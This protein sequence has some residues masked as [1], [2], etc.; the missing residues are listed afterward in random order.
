MA[1]KRPRENDLAGA[2][3]GDHDLRKRVDAA[4]DKDPKLANLFQ[5]VVM[6]LQK[7]DS[8]PPNL[9][10]DDDTDDD[11]FD[12]SFEDEAELLAATEAVENGKRPRDQDNE[13]EFSPNKKTKA[14]SSPSTALANR[15]LTERFGLG[16]FRLKQEAVITRILDGGSAVIVFPTGGGKSLCYQV[17]VV[18]YSISSLTSI[19]YPQ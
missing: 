9:S 2:L 17:W 3:A 13:D 7:Q 16:G 15:V 14:S 4:I 8:Q 1:A 10:F 6:H 11:E 18:K 12:A 19:R 5:D